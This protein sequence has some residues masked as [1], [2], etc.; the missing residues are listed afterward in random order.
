[1]G[2][3]SPAAWREG[4]LT[5]PVAFS[6]LHV[7]KDIPASLLITVVIPKGNTQRLDAWMIPEN[8]TPPPLVLSLPLGCF[9]GGGMQG[10]G[11][12]LSAGTQGRVLDAEVEGVSHQPFLP[13]CQ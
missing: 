4:W 7:P 5:G 10:W 12:L 9:L 3:G 2:F 11:P 8:C 1:M 6:E 13:H